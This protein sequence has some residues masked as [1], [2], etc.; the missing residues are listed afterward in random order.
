MGVWVM[1]GFAAMAGV[2]Y[3]M[4]AGKLMAEGKPVTAEEMQKDVMKKKEE[5]EKQREIKGIA[6]GPDGTI[7]GGGKGGL[8]S[9]KGETWEPVTGFTGH[10]V[11]ALA[12]DQAG[13]LYV[14]HHDGVAMRKDGAW[15]EIHEGEVHNI[16]LAADGSVLLATK[17]PASLMKRTADGTWSKVN[18]GLP[19]AP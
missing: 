14:V 12:V 4:S 19:V 3:L 2:P 10:D 17:K 16:A 7:F 15:S 5:P 1:I 6:S 13:S 9:L 8:F 11:K 18:D